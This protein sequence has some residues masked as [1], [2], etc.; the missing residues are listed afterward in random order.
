ELSIRSPDEFPELELERIGL[1]RVEVI[2]PMIGVRLGT[3]PGVGA[4]PACFTEEADRATP[5][6]RRAE[7]IA[8]GL[9]VDRVRVPGG[10]DRVPAAT[11]RQQRRVLD[12]VAAGLRAI[13]I[14]ERPDRRPL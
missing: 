10:L 7:W 11:V 8:G 2:V 4:E 1:D 6:S 12:D 14:G 5:C 13:E 9:E 3:E